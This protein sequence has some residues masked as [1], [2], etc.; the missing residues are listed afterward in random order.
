MAVSGVGIGEAAD[1]H[2]LSLQPNPTDDL[3]VLTFSPGANR[4]SAEVL[5]MTGRVVLSPASTSAVNGRLSMDVSAL[6]PGQYM[7][8]AVVDDHSQVLPLIV[9]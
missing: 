6:A 9:R 8:R 3:V 4:V 7:V 2:A 5:D 1:D